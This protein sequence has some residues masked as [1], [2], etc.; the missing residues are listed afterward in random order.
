MPDDIDHDMSLSDVL[1]KT[2]VKEIAMDAR[3]TVTFGDVKLNTD[4]FKNIVVDAAAG[5]AVITWPKKTDG[6]VDLDAGK[7]YEEAVDA[8]KSET[9]M[10]N[11]TSEEF[12]HAVADKLRDPSFH[13]GHYAGLVDP[14]TNVPDLRNK[15][16]HFLVLDGIASDKTVG[17]DESTQ[18]YK[19]L[20]KIQHEFIKNYGDDSALAQRLEDVL[21]T[22]DN[23]YDVDTGM[24]PF[25]NDNVYKGQIFIPITTN[26]NS[27]ANADN[28]NVKESIVKRNDWMYQT[29]DKKDLND[30]SAD[31]LNN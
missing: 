2:G 11:T 28:V 6:S 31:A 14:S 12:Q 27:G 19:P 8:V 17:Y 24:W 26:R 10:D 15:F 29:H 7:V 1:S 23:S 21:S 9:G 16:G 25:N 5:G 20:D 22:K 4:S 18:T 3:N 13:E 30:T